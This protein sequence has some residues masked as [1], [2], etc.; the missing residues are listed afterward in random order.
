VVG[1]YTVD[2]KLAEDMAKLKKTGLT[3]TMT[4]GPKKPAIMHR[5]HYG[6]FTDKAEAQKAVEMLKRQTGDGFM[7]KQ[8]DKYEVFAGSYALLSGAQTEQQR[9][10]AS[11]IKVSVQ[12][13]TVPVSSRKLTAGTFTD[14]TAAEAALKKVK[15]VVSGSP[16]LE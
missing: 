13:T 4:I 6:T 5:L 8:W 12:K 16:V 15:T 14:R 1:L 10:A 3:P 11:G 7:L 2:G 9:L